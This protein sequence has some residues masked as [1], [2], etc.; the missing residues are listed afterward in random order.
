MAEKSI[1]EKTRRLA[2]Q[3]P[4][5]GKEF[6]QLQGAQNQLL[7]I[8]AA[9]KQNLMEQRL[10]SGA[11]AEQNQILAQ[12]AEVGAQSVAGNMQLNQATA[13]VMGRY[14]L[15]QPRTSSQVKQQHR[16][17]VTRQNVTI[18]NNTTNITNNTVP[19]N[20]GGPIQG[21]PIQ[22]QQPQA[23]GDGAGGVYGKK[24]AVRK[25]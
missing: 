20:I 7:E 17:S 23:S 8:Q 3:R 15:N 6:Q 10:M 4:E 5:N 25:G 1:E 18:H 16:E 13:G 22:F 2:S 21:R 12:A 14:G 11:Q 19:A 9:Q 24:Y